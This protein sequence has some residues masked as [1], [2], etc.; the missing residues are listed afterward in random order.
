MSLTL[1]QTLWTTSRLVP[2]STDDAYSSSQDPPEQ[3]FPMCSLRSFPNK[4]EHTI[5]WA[6][7]LFQS[8]FVGPPETVNLY[9]S[10]PDYINTTLRQ[11]GNEKLILDSLKEF[12]VTG[13]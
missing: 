1:S 10:Q 2:T 5:A 4:I 13:K 3:S 11:Q 6:R 9:M 12:L 7:D 8:Y